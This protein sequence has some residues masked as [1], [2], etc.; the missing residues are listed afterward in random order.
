VAAAKPVERKGFM[1]TSL[2]APD[3]VSFSL[4]RETTRSI[5][6]GMKTPFS[7][8]MGTA[9][10]FN[11]LSTGLIN[12]NVANTSIAGLSEFPSFAAIFDE[13]FVTH[14]KVKYE[15]RSMF[16]YQPSTTPG[17]NTTS[18]G[19][20]CTALHHGVSAYS[21]AATAMENA[22]SR[23]FHTATPWIYTWINVESPRS[24]VVVAPETSSATSTQSWCLT[25]STAAGLYTGLVQFLNS[26]AIGTGSAMVTVGDVFVTYSL[27]FRL[28]A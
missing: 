10:A 22:T 17:T 5:M 20:V 2:G 18:T 9:L 15:P 23:V 7:T 19:L 1:S 13:F 6:R 12:A 3:T 4:F 21:S 28:R 11:T 14:I 26:S 27:M 25:A 16:Q 8:T 24:T